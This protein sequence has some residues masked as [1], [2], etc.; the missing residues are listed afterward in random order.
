MKLVNIC[1]EGVEA[2]VMG[3]SQGNPQNTET[4]RHDFRSG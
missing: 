3:P 4:I 1:S 2:R